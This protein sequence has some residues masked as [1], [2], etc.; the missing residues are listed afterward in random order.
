MTYSE[1][2][3]HPKTPAA[4]VAVSILASIV[5]T[6]CGGGGGGGGSSSPEPSVNRQTVSVDT[7]ENSI[8]VRQLDGE[9]NPDSLTLVEGFDN[10]SITTSISGD[11]LTIVVGDLSNPGTERF[12]VT[13]D[14]DTRYTINISAANTSAQSTVQQAE[15]LTEIPSPQ[16]LA[17]DDLRLLSAVLE[18]EYLAG[19][20]GESE[21]TSISTTASNNIESSSTALGNEITLLEQAL[22]DYQNSDITETDL[23]QRLS[24]ATS[25]LS[26][27]GAAGEAALDNVT[28]TLTAMGITLPSDLQGTTP[29]QYI[30]QADRYSRFMVSDYGSFDGNGNFSFDP[31]YDFFN[32]V[33]TYAN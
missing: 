28:N 4:T 11:E 16:T 17:G 19:D 31:S 7:A 12:T 26:D 21:K 5:L 6:A 3:V 24:A 18:I 23:A 9:I 20:I 32:A 2:G 15:T 22:A 8:E 27:L 33:F 25:T 30:E 14:K 29:L 13:T 1:S 10:P